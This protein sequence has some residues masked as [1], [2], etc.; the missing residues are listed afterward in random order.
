[1]PLSKKHY[2]EIAGILRESHSK[3]EAVEGMSTYFAE[4]NPRFDPL[5]FRKATKRQ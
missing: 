5:R 1:M 2:V 3:K 4:D